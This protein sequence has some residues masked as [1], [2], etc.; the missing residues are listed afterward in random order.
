[1][2]ANKTDKPADHSI[3]QATSNKV[4][5]SYAGGTFGRYGKPLSALPATTFLPLLMDKIRQN[6]TD[7]IEVLE[8]SCVK[9]SS[10]LSPSDFS[11]FYELILNRYAQGYRHF[12]V[13][14]VCGYP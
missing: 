5:L 6:L 9:D 1:M 4:Q 3:N 11:H 10:Q 12:I 2:T 7:N 13:I 14:T 8:N